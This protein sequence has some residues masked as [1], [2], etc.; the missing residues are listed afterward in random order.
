LG[1]G[2]VVPNLGTGD[3]RFQSIF[4]DWDSPVLGTGEIH[5]ETASIAARTSVILFGFFNFLRA[6]EFLA[7]SA[8]SSACSAD[9]IARHS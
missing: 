7:V 2:P 3:G 6:L 8:K 1:T 5:T 4:G 9:W